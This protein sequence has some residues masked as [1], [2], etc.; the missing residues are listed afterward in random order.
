MINGYI[1]DSFIDDDDDDDDDVSLGGGSDMVGAGDD[2]ED[3]LDVGFDYFDE[4][5]GK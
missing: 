4:F 2:V 5:I 3:D 1:I